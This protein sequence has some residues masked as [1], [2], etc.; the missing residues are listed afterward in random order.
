MRRAAVVLAL[1][2]LVT[3]SGALAR[4]RLGVWNDWGVFR[5]AA[6]PRCYAIAMAA[7]QPGHGRETQPYVTIAT[8]P[9]R[10]IH[11]EIHVRLSRSPAPGKPVMMVIGGQKFALVASGID[12]WAADRRM[13]AG[14]IAAMR[15][16]GDMTIATH[17]RDG[18]P[19]RD[20]YRLNGAASAMDAAS[21]GC[22]AS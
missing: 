5:D 18:R 11:G 3:A 10:A 14:I 7:D 15:A 4:D 21:L 22:A 2:G 8:W 13:D 17:G 6:V 9:R 19:I 1:A 16:G 20:S 12:A